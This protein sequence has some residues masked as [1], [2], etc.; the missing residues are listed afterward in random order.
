MRP[1]PGRIFARGT[2]AVQK[3]LRRRAAQA[4]A[5]PPAPL[6]AHYARRDKPDSLPVVTDWSVIDPERT[7]NEVLDLNSQP[8][9]LQKLLPGNA[10]RVFALSAASA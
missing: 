7:M 9:P 4:S 2:A 3:A 1:R 8:G 6:A 5:I 10:V